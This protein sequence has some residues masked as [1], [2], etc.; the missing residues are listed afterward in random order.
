MQFYL[1]FLEAERLNIDCV[2]RVCENQ[3]QLCQ[4]DKI[5]KN[6]QTP[7]S[8]DDNRKSLL[9]ARCRSL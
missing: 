9:L 5:A 7:K 6:V 4:S 8:D 3:W 2:T 1:Y